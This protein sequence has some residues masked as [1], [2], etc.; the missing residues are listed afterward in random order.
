MHGEPAIDRTQLPGSF[1][2]HASAHAVAKKTEWHSHQWLQRIIQ[3]LHQRAHGREWWLIETRG[4]ARQLHGTE[5]DL[6]RHQA[7]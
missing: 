1:E 6:G 7:S 2:A 4:T 3:P 5:I